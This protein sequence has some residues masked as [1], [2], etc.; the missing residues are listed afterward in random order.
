MNI[1][2][3][4]VAVQQG[5][6]KIN[7]L[8]AD[9]LLPQEID[10]ELNK[11]IMRFVNL[12]Y[13]KNNMYRKGFEESQKRI[14]D[15]RSLLTTHE[16]F[17][18]FKERR[19]LGNS[20]LINHHLKSPTKAI[21]T[22]YIDKF[23][24][25]SNYLYHIN[26]YCNVIS[27]PVCKKDVAFSLFRTT[28]GKLVAE[29]PL[30]K[31]KVYALSRRVEMQDY[32]PLHQLGWVANVNL[33]AGA[34]PASDYDDIDTTNLSSI[35]EIGASDI[36]N[37]ILWEASASDF[38][39][40]LVPFYDEDFAQYE[41]E[42]L[43]DYVLGLGLNAQFNGFTSVDFNKS[44]SQY[45]SASTSSAKGIIYDPDGAL[46]ETLVN[47][48][49]DNSG[50]G[51][52]P[53]YQ[54]YS[55]TYKDKTFFFELDPEV[56]N[57]TLTQEDAI[58]I[59]D[60]LLTNNKAVNVSTGAIETY[61]AN[62]QAHTQSSDIFSTK[63]RVGYQMRPKLSGSASYQTY[64]TVVGGPG[65]TANFSLGFNEVSPEDF[66][67]DSGQFGVLTIKS[68]Y[69]SIVPFGGNTADYKLFYP[70]EWEQGATE[71][72]KRW[73]ANDTY[74][75][76]DVYFASIANIGQNFPG[77]SKPIKYIQHDDILGLLN[78]PF[79]KPNASNVLAV[80]DTSYINIYSLEENAD[81]GNQSN[82]EHLPYSVKLKYLRRPQIV[83]LE[84]DVSAD[85]PEHTHEEIVAMTVSGI[86]EG[87]SDPRYKTHMGEL[88]KNE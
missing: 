58:S 10:I 20:K 71:G 35:D 76:D 44:Y 53:Y 55:E 38:G 62:N 31:F 83:S 67:V 80:F 19:F 16:E 4:H 6:D 70:A 66:L 26:S 11:S 9:S 43:Q 77:I 65:E 15:L 1:T 32:A 29:V 56:L 69:P 12:K 73:L 59:V 51:I 52:T 27:S 36:F 45:T 60:T 37:R 88:M 41:I 78:D 75:D 3:M 63:I 17:L 48:I 13:G 5:V 40:A 18:Y 82:V 87:I 68:A 39:E 14:D 64:T 49:L 8:Q 33:Y 30:S 42:D 84:N 46:E 50:F 57:F 86:L 74:L 28:E 24:L 2:E 54:T 23:K 79:N 85:L 72:M 61:D 25:P 81:M 47:S 22:L 21:D 7:S 34:T